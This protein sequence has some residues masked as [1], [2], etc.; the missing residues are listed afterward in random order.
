MMAIRNKVEELARQRGI[1]SVQKLADESGLNYNT[2][3]ALW[4]NK[5]NR[6]D[7]GTLEKLCIFFQVEPGEILS[8]DREPQVA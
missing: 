3:H 8:W 1:T 5:I 4:K 6:I 7:Y 2:A